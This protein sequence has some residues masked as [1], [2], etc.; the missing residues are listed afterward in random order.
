MAAK[1]EPLPLRLTRPSGGRPRGASQ[2]RVKRPP[3]VCDGSPRVA[4]PPGMA[5]L[6]QTGSQGHEAEGDADG[7]A[8]VLAGV[9]YISAASRL[10]LTG[11]GGLL[12]CSP[13]QQPGATPAEAEGVRRL[14]PPLPPL[15]PSPC[16]ARSVR[17]GSETSRLSW[18]KMPRPPP[19]IVEPKATLTAA[20][21]A[22]SSVHSPRL[23]LRPTAA[24]GGSSSVRRCRA[25]PCA[26]APLLLCLRGGAGLAMTAKEGE[27]TS[28]PPRARSAARSL[29]AYQ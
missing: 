18:L 17:L 29:D 2:V 22:S 21:S 14:P 23:L 24:S 20:C 27:R 8:A 16:E 7:S 1:R 11:V 13:A 28:M 25:D 3:A 6:G 19:P 4:L 10:H 26:A 12:L 5:R 15:L 9:G